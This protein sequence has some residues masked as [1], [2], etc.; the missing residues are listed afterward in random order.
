MVLIA[1]V[2][3]DVCLKEE[4]VE[5]EYWVL[6]QGKRSLNACGSQYPTRMCAT[7]ILL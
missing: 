2:I 1:I 4:I 7:I 3:F 6:S 5:S